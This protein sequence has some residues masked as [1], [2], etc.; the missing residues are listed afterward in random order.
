[1]ISIFPSEKMS[2]INIK[3]EQLNRRIQIYH[4]VANGNEPV[5]QSWNSFITPTNRS[6]FAAWKTREKC[7]EKTLHFIASLTPLAIS[8]LIPEF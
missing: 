6:L 4:T 5:Q 3:Y 8:D 1:M 7:E 2:A